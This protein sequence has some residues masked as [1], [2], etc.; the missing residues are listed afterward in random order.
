MPA[1]KKSDRTFSHTAKSHLPF[2]PLAAEK[3]IARF[4]LR[5]RSHRR[6]HPSQAL[7][8]H[9]PAKQAAVRNTPRTEPSGKKHAQ[10][11][12]IYQ[13]SERFAK[14]FVDIYQKIV[15]KH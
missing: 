14:I 10:F 7:K 15:Q 3:P 2:L 9:I 1:P 11:E 13:K 6:S 4:L 8:V 5:I 12:Q